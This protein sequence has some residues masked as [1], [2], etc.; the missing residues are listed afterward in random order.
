MEYAGNRGSKIRILVVGGNEGP[1][2]W[3]LKL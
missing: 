1:L 3:T 2:V